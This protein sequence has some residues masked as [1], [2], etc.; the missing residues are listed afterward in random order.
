MDM[1]V[2]SMGRHHLDECGRIV[3]GLE[4]FGQYRI[5]GDAAR[6][7]L[8]VS[9]EEGRS[10]L[11]VALDREDQ[12]LGFAWLVSRAAFDRSGYLRLIAVSASKRRHGVGRRLVEALEETHLHRGGI[13]LLVSSNNLPAMGFYEGLGYRQ[14]GLLPGY[15]RPELDERVLYKPGTASG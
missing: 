3:D 11:R 9:L 7:L 14:V 8:E 15:I 5:G 4:L 12:V 10:D 6:R 1:R 13:F 2:V